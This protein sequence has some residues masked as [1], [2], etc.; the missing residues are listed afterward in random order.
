MKHREPGGAKA[1]PLTD[2]E[3]ALLENDPVLREFK[4]GKG[5]DIRVRANHCSDATASPI[6]K[7]LIFSQI[8]LLELIFSLVL[9]VPN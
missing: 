6:L 3:T 9:F 8:M 2:S 1:R 4:R 5:N 7:S